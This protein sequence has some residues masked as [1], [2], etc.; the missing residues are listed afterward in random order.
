MGTDRPSRALCE[1]DGVQFPE[2]LEK[3]GRW[4]PAPSWA[5]VAAVR[6]I[7]ICL[8]AEQIDPHYH[9]RIT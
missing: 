9:H 3:Q 2:L 5:G 8:Y 1:L 4:P 7:L 6:N